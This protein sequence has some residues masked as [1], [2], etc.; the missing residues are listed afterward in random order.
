M[1][2]SCSEGMQSAKSFRKYRYRP[3]LSW[4]G[5]L[6][7]VPQTSSPKSSEPVLPGAVSEDCFSASVFLYYC[8]EMICD[9]W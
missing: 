2:N 8:M 4:G 3:K 6:A 9:Y 7:S 5:V 1:G